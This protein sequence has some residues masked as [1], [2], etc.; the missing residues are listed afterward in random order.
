M[1]TTPEEREQ[2]K[3]MGG[4]PARLVADIDALTAERDAL[5]KALEQV[6]TQAWAAQLGNP[7]DLTAI[8]NIA[9]AVLTAQQEIDDAR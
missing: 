3:S 2:I 4:F 8:A 6:R 9:D 1:K 7:V 5:R